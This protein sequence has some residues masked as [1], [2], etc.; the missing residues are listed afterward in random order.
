M[1]INDDWWWLMMINYDWWWLIMTNDDWWWLIMTI[2]DC[3][4]LIMI[5][6]DWCNDWCNDWW[7]L[8]MIDAVMGL[9]WEACRCSKSTSWRMYRP[10]QTHYCS[11]SRRQSL[12]WWL[13]SGLYLR[14]EVDLLRLVFGWILIYIQYQSNSNPNNPSN[15]TAIQA[16]GAWCGLWTMDYGPCDYGPWTICHGLWTMVCG[17][18]TMD[19]GPWNMDHGLWTTDFGAWAKEPKGPGQ[20]PLPP[21]RSQLPMTRSPHACPPHPC[22]PGPCKPGRNGRNQARSGPARPATPAPSC[23]PNSPK[24]LTLASLCTAPTGGGLVTFNLL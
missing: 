11:S 5:D 18:W 1:M 6:D 19:H 10:E 15:P 12:Q 9:F 23:H 7:W 3:W 14:R 13:C 16:T 17:L 8:M 4:R 20:G 22:D 2:D 24:P 21:V